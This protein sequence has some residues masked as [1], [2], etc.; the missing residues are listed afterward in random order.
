MR[1]GDL[2]ESVRFERRGGAA[3]VGGVVKGGWA[4]LAGPFRAAC[5]SPR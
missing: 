2:R 1:S 5:C 3:N 4:H